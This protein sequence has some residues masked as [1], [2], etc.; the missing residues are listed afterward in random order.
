M[1]EL[2]MFAKQTLEQGGVWFKLEE[3]KNGS[4][5]KTYGRYCNGWNYY[6]T[7][8]VFQVFD[9]AGKRLFVSESYLNA[10]TYYEN[11]RSKTFPGIAKAMAEQW[12]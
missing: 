7:P 9:M 1:S 12:G 8:P 4:L 6:N 3:S 2:E 5:Y 11:L 10:L